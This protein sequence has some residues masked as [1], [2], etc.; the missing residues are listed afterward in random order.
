MVER[1]AECFVGFLFRLTIAD[2]SF[3]MAGAVR[4]GRFVVLQINVACRFGVVRLDDDGAFRS[5]S[6]SSLFHQAHNLRLDISVL[7]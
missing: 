5:A 4:P 6:H 7:I 3:A 1:H 2:V